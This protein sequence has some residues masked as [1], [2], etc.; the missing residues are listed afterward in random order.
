M[1]MLH[2]VRSLDSFKLCTAFVPFGDF[3]MHECN[4]AE[5]SGSLRFRQRQLRPRRLNEG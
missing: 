1:I 2:T 4:I 3:R 5:K